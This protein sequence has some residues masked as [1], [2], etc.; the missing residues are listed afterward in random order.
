MSNKISFS[1]LECNLSGSALKVIAVLSM[2]ADH[3]AYFFMNQSTWLYEA[4]RCFGR[5]AFPVFAFL[6]AEGFC[7]THNRLRYFR[8]LLLFAIVSEVPWFM[9]NGNGGEHNVMFTLALGVVALG[10]LCKLNENKLLSLGI[11]ALIASIATYYHTDYEWRGVCMI[12]VFYMFRQRD[13]LLECA[14]GTRNDYLIHLYFLCPVLQVAFAFPLMA[15]YGVMG[16]ILAC[17]TILLYN[18][19]RGFIKG[20]IAK[21][22]FYAFYP[23]HLFVIWLLTAH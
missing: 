18:G 5:I 8:T 2:I 23:V 7:H 12:A 21:Y 22:A 14:A 15:H 4:M 6:I 20:C 17:T 16:A 19:E 13:N 10:V 1:P 11:V 9:L 3:C